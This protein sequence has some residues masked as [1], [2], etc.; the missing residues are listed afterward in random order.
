MQTQRSGPRIGAVASGYVAWGGAGLGWVAVSEL[1][2][3]PVSDSLLKSS[4]LALPREFFHVY[5]LQC[6]CVQ[7]CVKLCAHACGGQRSMSCV[8]VALHLHFEDRDSQSAWSSLIPASGYLFSTG[9]AAA[10]MPSLFI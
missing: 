6:V 4:G 9:I 7:A 5:L 10:A 8:S 3:E 2:H 1:L